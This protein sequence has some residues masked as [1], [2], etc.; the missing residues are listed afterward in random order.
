MTDTSFFRRRVDN[1]GTERMPHWGM[2]SEYG[3][4]QDV[5]IGPMD[6]YTWQMGNA[7]SRRSVRLGRSFDKEIAK[8][9]YQEMVDIYEHCG[10]KT[11]FLKPDS[12]LP[13]RSLKL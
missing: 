3:V 8:Q 9:Q 11:H 10:V 5:L 13:Y 4:L 12:N 6:N 1:G 7:M 2:N